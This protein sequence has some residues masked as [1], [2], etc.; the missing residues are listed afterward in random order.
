[1]KTTDANR[2]YYSRPADER[3]KTLADLHAAASTDR[4]LCGSKAIKLSGLSATVLGDDV[5]IKSAETGTIAKLTNW[6][7]NQLA[8]FANAPA[9]YLRTLP[10]NLAVDCLN[11]GLANAS[12]VK[13]DDQ[14]LYFRKG[15]D[16]L[17]LR[18]IT[19]TDY[20]RLHDATVIERI[21]RL[22]DVNPALDLP[23]VWEGGKG[24]AYRG[25]RDMFVTLIDG[26]SVVE[27]PTLWSGQ[28]PRMFRGLMI[29]NSEVGAATLE[30]L[31]F[32][33]RWICGNHMIGGASTAFTSKRRHVGKVDEAFDGID[34][35]IRE[36]FSR[37][38][39]EDVA[40]IER[41]ATTELASDRDGVITVGR[42]LGLTET[43]AEA[44][45]D[46]AEANEKNPR[47]VWG[48]ANGI[49]RVSQESA[50]QDDRFV[51][52]LLAA[53]LLKRYQLQAAN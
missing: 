21:S 44:S 13:T 50:Y 52:D 2:Q 17:T 12:T 42:S 27:D 46:S 32:W 33:F 25:D 41:L 43:I 23:P 40:T 20:S 53:K 6:S 48:F 1:M 37:P 35:K 8:R 18:S 38:A 31:T 7:G 15:P 24:G 30:I 26:G 19:S 49:T 29:R 45:Y 14:S 10:A 3:F 39:S 16:G 9:G 4:R 28:D 11:H 22:Q 51:L 34:Q 47:S 36:F 5:A